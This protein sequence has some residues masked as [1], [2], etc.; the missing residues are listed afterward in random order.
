MAGKPGC[1]E[2][3]G[4]S[5]TP[6]YQSWRDMK[7]R[8]NDPKHKRYHHYKELGIKVC[9]RW[10]ESFE[11]FLADMGVCPD[12]LTLDRIRGEDDYEPGNC[13]WTTRATQARNRTASGFVKLDFE[14]AQ[15][16]RERRAS[17]STYKALASE[18]G[19][20][21]GTVGFVL[22]GQSWATR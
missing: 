9:D 17:G 3:H 12:G 5:K 10:M 19:V 8:C 21:Q 6:T 20:S 16:M 2:T 15:Q 11:N 13:R 7:L 14:R 18:F 1:N 22:S 4:M